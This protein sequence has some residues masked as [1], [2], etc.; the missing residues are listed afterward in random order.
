MP[1]GTG[2]RATI[3]RREGASRQLFGGAIDRRVPMLDSHG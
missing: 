2:K 1:N 3:L